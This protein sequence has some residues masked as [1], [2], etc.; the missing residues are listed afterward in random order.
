MSCKEAE[1]VYREELKSPSK[2]APSLR[3]LEFFS[4]I[5]GWAE[6]FFQMGSIENIGELTV[7]EAIDINHI[8]NE[9]YRHNFNKSP[10]CKSI[11]TLTVDIIDS[12]RADMW[13]MSPPC[14]PFTRSNQTVVRDA[15]DPRSNAFQYILKFLKESTA[16]PRYIS[17]ENV[18]GFE[19][20]NCHHALIETLK[21]RNYSY[22]QFI[23]SPYQFNIPNERPR[24]YLLGV[25]DGSFAKI[26]SGVI[27]ESLP[28]S[29][30]K[31]STEL[32]LDF[33]RQSLKDFID[34]PEQ[35]NV[36]SQINESKTV[37][38]NI[39]FVCFRRFF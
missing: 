21:S 33:Q 23:L 17:L 35:R 11:E 12:Y 9:V 5:G 6:A 20:S 3:V 34:P 32:K 10:M 29:D 15:N 39:L 2:I 25:L 30:S 31:I 27:Q 1:D 38:S 24:Y 37:N 13:V 19:K 22:V 4:G 26:D 7:V 8:S 28:P 14:Q 16:P 18:V 36:S